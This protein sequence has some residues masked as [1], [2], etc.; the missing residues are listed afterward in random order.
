MDKAADR[1]GLRA[2]G[3][4]SDGGY[5]VVQNV[6]NGLY[7]PAGQ[8]TGGVFYLGNKV[9]VIRFLSARQ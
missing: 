2:A 8:R 7:G 1:R 9:G 6:Q 5:M 3:F 4:I